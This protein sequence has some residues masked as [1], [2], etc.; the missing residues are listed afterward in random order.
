LS[1]NYLSF[2]PSSGESPQGLLIIL[3]GWGGN[4]DDVGG[5]VPMLGL[6]NYQII[7]PDAPFTHYQFPEGRAWYALEREDYQGLPESRT[8]LQ[9]WLVS[10]ES[11]TGIPLHQTILAGFSQGGAMTL[12][13]GLSLPL[14]GLCVLSGYL[15]S[16]ASVSDNPSPVLIIHGKQD[17]VVPLIAA[18]R[19]REELTQ[20][21]VNVE[22]HELNMGHEI[23]TEVVELMK[24]FIIN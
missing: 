10:L 16:Q 9:D 4:G 7:C 5:I 6:S 12:D 21:G 18:Q 20:L 23:V 2:P 1:L 11:S 8:L 22:Y 15:H 19:A 14:A 13:V 24:K 17:M 3:H